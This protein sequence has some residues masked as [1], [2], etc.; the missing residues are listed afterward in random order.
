MSSIRYQPH[1]DDL[2][3]VA[4]LLVIFQ[5]LGDWRASA[6]DSLRANK[7]RTENAPEERPE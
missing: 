5:H 4:V 7:I 1:I 6:P 3:A 2:R